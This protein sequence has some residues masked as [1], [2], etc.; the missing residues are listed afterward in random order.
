MVNMERYAINKSKVDWP[1]VKKEVSQRAKTLQSIDDLNKI[2]VYLLEQLGDF[3]GQLIYKGKGVKW[4][5]TVAVVSKEI[6]A[7]WDK[8]SGIKTAAFGNIA[9]LRVPFMLKKNRE[10]DVK[11]L[12]DSICKLLVKQPKGVIIDLRINDGGDMHPMLL[13]LQ[14]LLGERNIMTYHYQDQP[15][16]KIS[17]RDHSILHD[18]IKIQSHTPK[19]K[20]DATHLPV[21][22]LQS[23]QTASSGENVIISFKGRPN[24]LILGENSAGYT[25]IN[26]RFDFTPEASL[27][28]AVAYATDRNGIRYEGTIKPDVYINSVDH[29]ENLIRD[30]K[31]LEAIKWLRK[32]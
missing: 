7:E 32:F 9:Y 24:T 11:A 10:H 29:F 1:A 28:L 6:Q 23:A 13:G 26:T 5:P 16:N 20:V 18:T 31:V 3:H 8:N 15:P 30:E 27:L 17:L 22:L 14:Q 4:N 2:A 19:C 25:T 21:V 12:S